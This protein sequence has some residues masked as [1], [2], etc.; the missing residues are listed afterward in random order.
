MNSLNILVN[1]KTLKYMALENA[2]TL[3]LEEILDFLD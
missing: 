3:S 1:G 2:I